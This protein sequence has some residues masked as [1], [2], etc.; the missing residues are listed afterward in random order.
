MNK[1]VGY[2]VLGIV[3]GLLIGYTLGISTVIHSTLNAL[4]GF[5]SVSQINFNL[6]ETK[7]VEEFNSTIVPEINRVAKL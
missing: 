5:I 2:F 6:N 7:L 3:L 4:Q 1:V